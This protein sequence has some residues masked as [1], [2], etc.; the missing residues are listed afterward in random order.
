MCSRSNTVAGGSPTVGESEEVGRDYA[1]GSCFSRMLLSLFLEIF[2]IMMD[3][4]SKKS[5][6]RGG[7]DHWVMNLSV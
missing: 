7:H 3:P 4:L 6:R 1:S 5:Y 2:S